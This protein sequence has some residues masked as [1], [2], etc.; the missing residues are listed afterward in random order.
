MQTGHTLNDSRSET[1]TQT[2]RQFQDAASGKLLSVLCGD[3]FMIHTISVS[4]SQSPYTQRVIQP[5]IWEKTGL[6]RGE[7]PVFTSQHP[8]W[9]AVPMC[10]AFPVKGKEDCSSVLAK[11]PLVLWT[12]SL[13]ALQDHLSYNY[14]SLSSFFHIV[15]STP[16]I[17]SS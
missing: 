6:I 14:S 12:P 7:M 5:P 16:L 9:I 8:H 17:C 15:G 10:S 3:D 4:H 13:P 11:N 1:S 2:A